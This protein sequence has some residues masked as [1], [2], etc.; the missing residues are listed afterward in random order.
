VRVSAPAP[1]GGFRPTLRALATFSQVVWR[2]RRALL[3]DVE[4]L[5]VHDVYLLPLARL[6]SRSLRIPFLYDAHEDYAAMESG[7]LPRWWLKAAT[8][9][10]TRLARGAN[11]VVVPGRTRSGRWVSVGIPA[12]VVLRN[13][14]A[15]SPPNEDRPADWD[16]AYVSAT[17]DPARRPDV[18]LEVAR[19]RPD[20][21]FAL[22]GDGRW[23]REVE[24]AA[25]E[26]PNVDWLGWVDDASAVLARSRAAFYGLDPGHSYA[27][28]ACP[29]TLFDALRARRPL[30]FFCGGEPE[31]LLARFRIGIR[32]APTADAVLEA[33]DDALDGDSWE[34]E[35]ALAAIDREESPQEYVRAVVGA[36]GGGKK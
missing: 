29:N 26:L 31:E 33:L 12:P 3:D 8:A 20:L 35:A 6:L 23:A 30:I 25:R 32:C 27:N 17:L 18:F 9:L 13:R 21:R 2:N 34:C 10:E 1:N 5:V 36:A 22:A 15:G 14:G 7:R 11:A 28:K 4:V 19:R 24:Q 16:L